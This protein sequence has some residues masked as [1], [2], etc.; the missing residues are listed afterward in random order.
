MNVGVAYVKGL[1]PRRSWR[2]GDYYKLRLSD[3]SKMLQQCINMYT[4]QILFG[5]VDMYI[6][7]T[8]IQCYP[9]QEYSLFNNNISVYLHMYN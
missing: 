9:G 7:C 8:H 1:E 2:Q 5:D 4:V 6:H 3:I